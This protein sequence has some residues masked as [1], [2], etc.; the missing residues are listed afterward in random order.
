MDIFYE[1]SAGNQNA[2]RGKR[3][4]N[5]IN[6]ISIIFVVI[7]VFFGFMGIMTI[8]TCSPES[9]EDVDMDAYRL[10]KVFC[11]TCLFIALFFGL[12]A[13][14]LTRLKR[15]YNVSYDYAFVSGELRITKVFNVN[16]RKLVATLDCKD[17]IQI[18]KVDS[19]SY[20]RYAAA[21][22]TAVVYCTSNKEPAA[23]KA[24]I[25]ILAAYNGKKLF[26]LE[27][28]ELLVAHMLKFVKRSVLATDYQSK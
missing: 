18:G 13:F 16:K 15:L 26:V 27:C 28:R 20:E 19:P 17:I 2:Q 25:Y 21:P 7:T 22:D 10:M 12:L 9:F 14:Y 11:V 23:D 6:V 24:F 3:I 8:P 5:I 1:E 4:Y